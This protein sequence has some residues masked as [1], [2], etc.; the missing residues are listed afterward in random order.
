MKVWILLV[1]VSLL[2]LSAQPA[3]AKCTPLI[4][5]GRELL[6]KANL[7]EDEAGKVKGLLD[8]AQKLRDGGDHAN[9]VVKA[10]EAL[11]LLKKK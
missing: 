4:N 6:T 10:N 3:W 7:P 2:I 9:G 1:A 8:E 5:E 11:K